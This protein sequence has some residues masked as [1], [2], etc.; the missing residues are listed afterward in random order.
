MYDF[1][2]VSFASRIGKGLVMTPLLKRRWAL[3]V[4]VALVL[5]TG[6]VAVASAS[7]PLPL[8]NKAYNRVAPAGGKQVGLTLIVSRSNARRLVTG[9]LSPPLGSEF[10][11][12]AGT[13][14][15]PKAPRN[16]SLAKGETPFALFGFPG[17]TLRLRHGH[18]G[19]SV[20]R[21]HSTQQLLGS[22]AKP[23]KLTVKLTGTV[24]N[25]KTIEGTIS[26]VGGPCTTRKPLP[27][28]VTLNRKLKPP[29][30]TP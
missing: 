19:F 21:T 29:P 1:V 25:S 18:Y 22:P 3:V 13:L 24:L 6:G 8:R 23:F 4:S 26:A 7:A 11:V 14:P 17:A 12:S 5:A 9:P 28:R 2:R 30:P 16:P 27:W 10:A 15:C 20:K